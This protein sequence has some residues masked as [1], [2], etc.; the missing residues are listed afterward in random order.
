MVFLGHVCAEIRS[1]P[2]ASIVFRLLVSTVVFPA[3][4]IFSGCLEILK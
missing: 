1:S 4:S 3:C 2:A